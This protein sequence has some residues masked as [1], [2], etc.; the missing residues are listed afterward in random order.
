MQS[1][2]SHQRKELK[3]PFKRKP[4]TKTLRHYEYGFTDQML[5][6]AVNVNGLIDVMCFYDFYFK[7][8]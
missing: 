3:E 7:F 1:V 2:T 5:I 8:I 6:S 4:A